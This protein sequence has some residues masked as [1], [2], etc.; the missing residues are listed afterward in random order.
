MLGAGTIT[1]YILGDVEPDALALAEIDC[2]VAVLPGRSMPINITGRRLRRAREIRRCGHLCHYDIVSEPE[3]QIY[4]KFGPVAE[5]A[6]EYVAAQGVVVDECG[7]I[8]G[9]HWDALCIGGFPPRAPMR[10]DR[11]YSPVQQRIYNIEDVRTDS[12]GEHVIRYVL[13]LKGEQL[14]FGV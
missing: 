11:I 8:S 6:P 14:R 13:F 4:C 9:L 5:I 12:W 7:I 1:D 10:M 2:G 3:K